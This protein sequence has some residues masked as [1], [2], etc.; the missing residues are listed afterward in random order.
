MDRQFGAE[1]IRN[2]IAWFRPAN[3]RRVLE[4]LAG[5]GDLTGKYACTVSQLV[6]AWTI[7]QPG[8]TFAL[9]GARQAADV[10][11]NARAADLE[12]DAADLARI[13]CDA[14]ALGA[15]LEG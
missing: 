14:E 9:C 6:I 3:R 11:E 2:K 13:R 7:A 10:V 4:M 15:P 1:A 12:L 5:W 8:L